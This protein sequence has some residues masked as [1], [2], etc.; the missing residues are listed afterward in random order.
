MEN[1]SLKKRLSL[2]ALIRPE[3]KLIRP[4]SN[5]D[6]ILYV[7]GISK[8]FNVDS[9]PINNIIITSQEFDSSNLSTKSEVI[10]NVNVSGGSWNN[11]RSW[12]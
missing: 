6:T 8:N 3:S 12:N 2:E 9:R 10:T 1:W 7:D 5:S 4:I 11:S